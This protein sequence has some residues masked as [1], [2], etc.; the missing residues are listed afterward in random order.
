MNRCNISEECQRI[1]F[2]EFF[3]N[4]QV[5]FYFEVPVFCRS[6]DL[7]SRDLQNDTITAIE[8][9]INDWKRALF[10]ALSVALCFDFLAICVPKPKTS[11]GQQTIID[12]CVR[13]GVGL[14]FFDPIL[15]NFEYTV[16][17]EKVC[18]IWDIQR[19]QVV[20]YLEV[21]QNERYIA[22]FAL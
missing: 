19:E 17:G 5:E 7:V 10:Q 16:I 18:N 6:V 15:T 2:A 1:K 3:A 11:K 8:F 14:Y 13:V 21:A 9:K 4:N 20:K 22:S 12:E